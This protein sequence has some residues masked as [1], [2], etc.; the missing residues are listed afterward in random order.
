MSL[1]NIKCKFILYDIFFQIPIKKRLAIING[2]KKYYEKLDYFPITN[3]LY[4][5]IFNY[6]N[7][8][9]DSYCRENYPIKSIFDYKLNNLANEIQKK[10]PNKSKEFFELIQ[11]I[12]IECIK[13]K[14]IYI[15]NDD[16]T[17]EELF[18]FNYHK[19]IIKFDID[20]YE[21]LLNSSKILKYN[22]NKIFGIDIKI[23]DLKNEIEEKLREEIFDKIENNSFDSFK[24]DFEPKPEKVFDL[25][26]EY[27][28]LL[29]KH[30][31][32]IHFLKINF[33]DFF[34]DF[35][36]NEIEKIFYC[37]SEFSK[38][39][40]INILFFKDNTV[41]TLSFIENYKNFIKNFNKLNEF[42]FLKNFHNGDT[43]EILYEA[44][45]NKEEIINS[46]EDSNY[47]LKNYLADINKNIK[48]LNIEI[49]NPCSINGNPGLG[50]FYTLATMS[51]DF[52]LISEFK[53]LEQFTLEYDWPAE[54]YFEFD[55]DHSLS[56]ALNSLKKLKKVTFK[57][58]EY[59]LKI[60]SLLSVKDAKFIER[61]S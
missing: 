28:D 30:F 5:K 60:I 17:Y 41:R 56:K 50:S 46:I 9:I 19:Y 16:F 25:M 36:D 55:F 45:K 54:Y 44:F 2:S 3:G 14:N 47:I 57:Y 21:M 51:E 18:K 53:N 48:L 40:S 39:N 13:A 29:K 49:S 22:I 24:D 12:I 4:D 52:S 43:K 15:L 6:L 38:R 1:L 11:E 34:N 10:F 33:S 26:L 23:N 27:L 42:Y 31:T 58:D 8:N 20:F 32:C 61:R 7:D 59:L 35:N 37:I